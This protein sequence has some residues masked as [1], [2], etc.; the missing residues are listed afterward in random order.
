MTRLIE[1]VAGDGA[2]GFGGDG[3]PATSASLTNP[4]GVALDPA[5]NLYIADTGNHRVRKVAAGSHTITT[6]AGSGTG[7]FAGDG[8]PATLAQLNQPGAVAVGP[9]GALY[10]GDASN[11]RVRRVDPITA[12]IETVAGSSGN[13]GSG[14]GAAATSAGLGA[15][16][17]VKVDASGDLLIADLVRIRRVGGATGV[18]TTVVGPVAPYGLGPADQGA[19]AD[20]RGLVLG[21]DALLIAG[22]TSGTVEAMRWEEGWLEAV[23][24]RYGQPVATGVLAKFRASSFGTVGGV[25]YDAA[26]GRIYLA[27]TSAHRLHVV[28]IVDADDEDTWTIASLAGSTAGHLD[29]V[30]PTARFD[31]PAGLFF[32]ASERVLYVADAGNHVVRALP[33][34]A[35]G[36]AGPVSTVA[37]TPRTF[38]FFGDGGAASAALLYGPQAVT[39]CGNGDLFIADTVNQRIRRIEAG[40]GVISTVLGDGVASSSGQGAPAATFPVDSPLGLACDPFGNLVVTSRTV[41]RLL[42]AA[43]DGS[44]DGSGAVQT[45]YGAPP[46]T[47]YPASVTSC[48]SGVVVLD[49]ETV[50]VADSCT[51]VLVELWRQPQAP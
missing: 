42:V 45:I 48:L 2:A 30:A 51:G 9:D 29:G 20:P 15:P 6:V 12:I 28:T 47:S 5:G 34:D 39:R 3:G 18:I 43:D 46:R 31:S 19:L 24:G 35:T 13:D 4:F 27:E 23:A 40:S 11:N 22:G 17:G 7:G 36:L 14:D 8:G 1:T 16:W 10:V 25:A 50:Q 41:V 33:I 49:E 38:G 32:D 21:P 26:L 44:V 37:G